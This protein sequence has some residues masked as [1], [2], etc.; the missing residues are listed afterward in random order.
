MIEQALQDALAIVEGAFQRNRVNVGIGDG[1]HLAALH[2]GDAIVRVHDEDVD[3]VETAEGLDGGSTGVAGG[4]ADDGSA[5]A[6]RLQHMI[7][8]AAEKLHGHVLEGERRTVEEFEHEEVVADLDQG[9]HCRMAEGRIGGFDHGAEIRRADVASHEGGHD[10]LGHLRISLAGEARDL[11]A[12]Q[13]RIDLRNIE[14]A[15]ACQPGQQGFGE[16]QD[17]RFAAGRDILHV[18]DP[19][20]GRAE[21]DPSSTKRPDRSAKNAA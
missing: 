18:S 14:A 16:G 1:R 6:P 11:G 20:G 12:R 9:R 2:I 21:R 13:A 5:L 17:G 7:H 8:H 19:D 15:I 4:G 3:L 10:R